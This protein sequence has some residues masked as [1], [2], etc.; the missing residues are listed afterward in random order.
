MVKV[1]S[2][3]IQVV[4]VSNDPEFL[5]RW[6]YLCACHHCSTFHVA[7]RL[8][9]NF[10]NL[11]EMEFDIAIVSLDSPKD[12]GA[13]LEYLEEVSPD[14]IVIPCSPRITAPEE[15]PIHDLCRSGVIAS[16]PVP[17]GDEEALVMALKQAHLKKDLNFNAAA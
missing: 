1:N 12:L 10:R 17:T 7:P 14:C 16:L 15:T 6:M 11:K 8:D 5:E 9:G 2:R 3:R 13:A 4:L